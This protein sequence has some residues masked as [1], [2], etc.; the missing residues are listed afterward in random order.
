MNEWDVTKKTVICFPHAGA[1]SNVYALWS[2]YFGPQFQVIT[3]D[4]PQN[5]FE[6]DRS[7]KWETAIENLLGKLSNEIK[8]SYILFGHSMGAM[9]CFELTRLISRFHLPLPSHIFISSCRA[10]HLGLFD[11]NKPSFRKI[12]DIQL[13]EQLVSL[14][15]IPSSYFNQASIL[16][17][18]LPE[19]RKHLIFCEEYSYKPG[20]ALHVPMTV[21]GGISDPLVDKKSL[22]AWRVHTDDSFQSFFLSGNHF[23]LHNQTYVLIEKMKR[24]LQWI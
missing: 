1:T 8:D 23:Y 22:Q 19:V 16:Q 21:F 20:S 12:T 2:K 4:Y 5:L 15:G 10:P 14:Q 17:D 24:V 3:V 13:L 9:L 18:W 6:P 7:L 11:S